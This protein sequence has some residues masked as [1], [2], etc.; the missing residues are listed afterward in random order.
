MLTQEQV[1]FYHENGYL[2]VEQ[3]F[4]PPGNKRTGI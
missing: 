4:K 1:G 3:L 2:K